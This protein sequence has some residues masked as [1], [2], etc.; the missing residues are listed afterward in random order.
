MADLFL[1]AHLVRGEPAFDIAERMECP[2]CDHEHGAID[3]DDPYCDLGYWWI[4]PTSGHRAYPSD[5]YKLSHCLDG[6]GDKVIN[7]LALPSA[8]LPDHYANQPAAPGRGV[9]DLSFLRPKLP[10]ITRRL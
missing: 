6:N 3:C 7:N 1:I 4:I 5:Y 9:T 8:D 10:A 2:K